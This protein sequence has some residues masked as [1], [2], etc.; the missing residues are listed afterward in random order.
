M[1]FGRSSARRS[2]A[3][4]A[5]LV[6]QFVAG[7]LAAMTALAIT[8]EN[9]DDHGDLRERLQHLFANNVCYSFY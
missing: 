6:I 5:V 1:L 4:A 8:I 9:G 3:A 2:R 7:F